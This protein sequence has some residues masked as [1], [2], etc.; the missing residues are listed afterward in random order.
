MSYL[1][2]TDDDS[3]APN[4]RGWCL[5]RGRA[6]ALLTNVG[7]RD[8]VFVSLVGCSDFWSTKTNVTRRWSLVW[9]GTYHVITEKISTPSIVLVEK[10]YYD[11]FLSFITYFDF[12]NWR[13]LER[14]LDSNLLLNRLLQQVILS[15]ASQAYRRSGRLLRLVKSEV[16]S[17]PGYDVTV[18]WRQLVVVM[19]DAVRILVFQWRSTT[20]W[21]PM[22]C[23]CTFEEREC[24]VYTSTL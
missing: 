10:R 24:V 21:N 18:S 19:C 11:V 5:A 2:R 22:L 7:C 14:S 23:F 4:G 3:C 13:Q 6:V 20:L 17:G 16:G 15:C 12:S 8:V 9:C 1:R